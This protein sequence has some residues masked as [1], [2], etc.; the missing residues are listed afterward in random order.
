MQETQHGDHQ[1]SDV[2]QA[3]GAEGL[4]ESTDRVALFRPGWSQPICTAIFVQEELRSLP[5][6]SYSR[7]VYRDV[8]LEQAA[9]LHLLQGASL[10][11][12]FSVVLRAPTDTL[13]STLA[14]CDAPSL[15]SLPVMIPHLVLTDRLVLPEG[16]KELSNEEVQR[17]M[18]LSE[19]SR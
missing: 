15:W 19:V 7:L 5:S 3:D 12:L 6:F 8:R 4:Y 16:A 13:A 2:R 11:D 18:F 17:E 1:G 9:V 10:R 14:T